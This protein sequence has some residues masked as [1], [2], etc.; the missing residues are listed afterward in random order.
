MGQVL[1]K[2]NEKESKDLNSVAEGFPDLATWPPELSLTV[3]SHLNATDLCLA[4][5]VWRELAQDEVLWQRYTFLFSTLSALW[6]TV[7][8]SSTFR[9][10]AFSYMIN[11]GFPDLAT[12]PPELSLTVLSHLNATDL[13]LAS[14]VWRELAQDEVLWQSLCHNQWGYITL[15]NQSK[16]PGFS[17]HKLYLILDEGTVTFNADAFMGMNYF[18]KNGLVYDGALEIAKFLHNTRS[19][20]PRQMRLYLDVRFSD[21]V[22]ILC[23]SLIMLSVDLCSPH[24]KNKMSKREFIRNVRHAIHKTDDELYGHLY[25]DVYLRGHIAPNSTD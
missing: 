12:W 18:V 6:S 20:N 8:W 3:L 16:P 10:H 13:C 7:G 14:C 4:S 23:F 17:Y 19:L 22:Y 25:D 11:T 15:Y 5:C 21:M 24:V 1:K 2:L 9:Y